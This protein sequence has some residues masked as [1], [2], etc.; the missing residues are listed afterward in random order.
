VSDVPPELLTPAGRA[1][2]RVIT[3]WY[4]IRHARFPAWIVSLCLVIAVQ[5]VGFGW[6]YWRYG[7]ELEQ[8]R[9][10]LE[11]LRLEC[12]TYEPSLDYER[13]FRMCETPKNEV[14]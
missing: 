6:L 14:L 7:D 8:L 2:R 5:L 10:E 4:Q 12:P 13:M 1:V 3:A 9:Y 11:R